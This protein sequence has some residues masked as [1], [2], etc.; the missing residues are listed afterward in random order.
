MNL[1][2]IF[3]NTHLKRVNIYIFESMLPRFGAFLFLPILLRF[4]NPEIWAEIVLMIAISEILSKIYLFGFQ[5]SIFRFAKELD[6]N[7]KNYIFFKLVKRVFT[8]SILFLIIFELTNSYFWNIF[9]IFE[10]GLP[11]RSA[12]L[13][14]CFSSINLFFIQYIKSLQLSRKLFIGSLFYTLSNLFLQFSSIFYIASNYGKSDRMIV[15]A[16]LASLGI[17]SLIRTVYYLKILKIS[18]FEQKAKIDISKFYNF[19][20]PAAG[21]AFVAIII[22]HGSKLIIQ[23]TINL[24][25]VGKYFSYLSYA[26]IIF[27]IFAA[28]QEYFSPTLYKLNTK[29]TLGFRIITLYFWTFGTIIYLTIFNKFSFLFI[30]EM[31]SISNTIYLLIFHIQIASILRSIVGV[32]YEINECLRQK[33]LLLLFWSILFLFYIP[34]INNLES[35]LNV[36]L[37]FFVLLGNSLI[38]YSKEYRVTL[39]FNFLHALIYILFTQTGLLLVNWGIIML[40]IIIFFSFGFFILNRFEKLRRLT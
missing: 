14:S 29:Q 19:A 22:S 3:K 4:V 34:M 17:S 24:E 12:L 18:F 2:E 33:F 30:P 7:Q 20:R 39:H 15:T 31:Y 6:D 9:F 1:L 23:N 32:F 10:Y 38:I 28:T 27:V 16:Y 36:Y 13:I 35:F 21:I 5:S 25:I 26:S 11:L 8:A 37:L 40:M